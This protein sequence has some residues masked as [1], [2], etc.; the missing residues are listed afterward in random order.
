MKP[1]LTQEATHLFDAIAGILLGCFLLLVVAQLVV[2]LV[3]FLAGDSIYQIYSGVFEIPRP[4][5]DQFLLS[6]LTLLKILN[7]VLFLTPFIAIKLMLR[8]SRGA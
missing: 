4:E 6:S 3:L 1:T 8:G 7:V 5:Y 2:W